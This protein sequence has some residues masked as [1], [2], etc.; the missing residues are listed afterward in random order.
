MEFEEQVKPENIKIAEPNSLYRIDPSHIHRVAL[1]KSGG[2][3]CFVKISL[4]EHKFNL[5]G[6]SINPAISG[7]WKFYMRSEIRNMESKEIKVMTRAEKL[8][9]AYERHDRYVHYERPHVFIFTHLEI[10]SVF[11]EKTNKV[12]QTIR[13]VTKS[14]TENLGECYRLHHQGAF[15]GTM[16]DNLVESIRLDLFQNDLFFEGFVIEPGL[17][18]STK[19]ECSSGVN[20]Q[21]WVLPC[22]MS[23]AELER[24]WLNPHWSPS[25]KE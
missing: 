21:G 19:I 16:I 23:D 20:R 7:G 4:S 2:S 9:L 24:T 14:W 3:R 22:S 8:K 17:Q 1:N 12:G 25:N 10:F 5:E 6:N 15:R 13:A 18:K 11:E